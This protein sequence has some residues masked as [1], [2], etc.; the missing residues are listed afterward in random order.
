MPDMKTALAAILA[1]RQAQTAAPAPQ[2]QQTAP[3]PPPQRQNRRT[4]Y[5]NKAADP[6]AMTPEGLVLLIVQ[7]EKMLNEANGKPQWKGCHWIYSGGKDVFK[8]FFPDLDDR[9]VTDA[10]V[11]AGK[12]HRYLAKRGPVFYLPEDWDEN[13]RTEKQPS[14]RAQDLASAIQHIIQQGGRG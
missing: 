5:G 13:R 2:P 7:A 4:P 11:N 12:L 14:T 6:N 1:N 10:M 3:A 9:T 8:A